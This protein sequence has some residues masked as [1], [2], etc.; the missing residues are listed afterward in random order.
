MP[1]IREI[2]EICA[3][4]FAT[5]RRTESAEVPLSDKGCT[6]NFRCC[7][8]QFYLCKSVKSVRD[9]IYFRSNLFKSLKSVSNK[10][11]IRL[12]TSYILNHQ[13]H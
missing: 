3:R 1:F 11:E 6:K 5:K 9:K 4:Y 7:L 13:K 8:M 12:L 10:T 2:C